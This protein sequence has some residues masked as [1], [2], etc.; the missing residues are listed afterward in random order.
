MFYAPQVGI[1]SEAGGGAS[2]PTIHGSESLASKTSAAQP[3]VFDLSTQSWTAGDQLLAMA[4]SYSSVVGTAAGATDD[5]YATILPVA[6]NNIRTFDGTVVGGALDASVNVS[7]GGGQRS[8]GGLITISGSSGI[9]GSA[10]NSGTDQS[11]VTPDLTTS[12]NNC[13]VFGIVQAQGAHNIATLTAA[14]PAGWTFLFAGYT[15]TSDAP[16]SAT[17]ATLAIAYKVQATAGAVGTGTW[18]TGLGASKPWLTQT[19]AYAP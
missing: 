2:A 17:Q 15:G 6:D 4:I 18:T 5:T 3:Q 12:V 1:I 8:V 13:L 16:T 10:E 11:P 19:I 9:D 14:L 7:F